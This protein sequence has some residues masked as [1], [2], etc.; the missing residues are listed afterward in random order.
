MKFLVLLLPCFLL[1]IA[2]SAKAVD[3]VIEINQARALAG[4]VTELDTPGFP[5]TI[6]SP[7]SYRLTGNLALSSA[8]DTGIFID[9][10]DVNID[11]NGFAIQG[12]SVCT[13]VPVTSCTPVA[14]GADHGYGVGRS[15]TN[16]IDNVTVRNGTIRGMGASGISLGRYAHVI[17]VRSIGNVGL[18]IGVLS[19][20]LIKDCTVFGGGN[21]GIRVSR[22]VDHPENQLSI[23]QGTNSSGNKSYGLVVDYTSALVT[24]NTMSI[25]GSYG[26]NLTAETGYSNNVFLGNASGTSEG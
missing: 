20:S 2:G 3:G 6:S 24:G 15:F 26:M 10:P 9:A 17:N 14:T 21:I 25:N 13:G 4:G 16:T 18:G 11:L 23:V 8:N 5:V 19:G 7:G 22:W 1:L 12:V